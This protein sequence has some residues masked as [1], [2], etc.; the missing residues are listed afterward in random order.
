MSF[1]HLEKISKRFG[2]KEAV[3]GLSLTLE[4]GEIVGLIGP[5]GSGKSTLAKIVT[6]HVTP[7][8]GTLS[9]N[10]TRVEMRS[11]SDGTSRGLFLVGQHDELF[12]NLTVLDNIL[13]GQEPS[14]GFGFF[15]ILNAPKAKRLASDVLAT[16][17]IQNVR[18]H[19]QVGSLSG[20][21]RKAVAL[22][23]ALIWDASLIVFDETS[24]S[25]GVSE[26]EWF[27]QFMDQ[28]AS[29]GTCVVFISHAVSEVRKAATRIISLDRGR[30]ISDE[31]AEGMAN[32]TIRMQMA[33]IR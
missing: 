25:L 6:G 31:P 13:L 24:N 19:D 7:D 30:V 11:P 4:R 16:M 9:V 18:L 12:S 23:R 33:G 32:Q 14:C 29:S 22:A 15:R 21:Q 5:N 8:R 27:L 17:N 1:L 10:E 26:Q 2:D 3:A 20:G 28:L